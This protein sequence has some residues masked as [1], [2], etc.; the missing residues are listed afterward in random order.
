M[1]IKTPT[2]PRAK[3]RCIK[4]AIYILPQVEIASILQLPTRSTITYKR[5]YYFVHRPSSK[6]QIHLFACLCR[7]PSAF[8]GN[9]FRSYFRAQRR[10]LWGHFNNVLVKLLRVS[11][12]LQN[13][14]RRESG[15]PFFF[16]AL[17]CFSLRRTHANWRN[18]GVSGMHL[19][20]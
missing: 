9:I 10:V 11:R 19:F 3:R 12:W 13:T 2:V 18:G 6:I 20:M 16:Q 8:V 4:I 1:K 5:A 14:A 15:A 7:D 17:N